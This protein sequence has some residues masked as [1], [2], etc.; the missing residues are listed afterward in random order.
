[1]DILINLA[2]TAAGI[3]ML[4]YGGNWLV[5]GGVSVA[6]RIGMSS[7]VVGMTVVA[8]G[9]STP[10][11]A[12]SV[13]AAGKYGDIILGNIVG[14]NIA[15]VG[16]VIGIATILTTLVV[17]RR[18]LRLEVPIMVGFSALLVGLSA[19]GQISQIDG[20]ILLS[21]LGVFSVYTFWQS[22][23]HKSDEA[24]P[25]DTTSYGRSFLLMGIGVALL[26][27][28][29]ILTVDNAVAVA[30][31]VGIPQRI[32]GITVI[33]VGTSLPELITSI[34]AIRR[35]HTDIGVGNIIGSN[36][37]NILLIG[38]VSASIASIHVVPATF[39]DYTIMILFSLVL[40]AAFRSGKLRWPVGLA[41]VAGY[42]T[43]ILSALL[44]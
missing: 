21:M 31:T 6:R 16:M 17:G 33:A 5:S 44:V 26:Y 9:T 12:A 37:Y 8:Y 34:I 27:A 43:Y 22:K 39:T 28:G 35:G 24:L 29:A 36:I 20:V 25:A 30:E 40:F 13:A 14:S 3:I 11:L 19:D 2:L 32:I 18:T 15:N 4:C 10:E 23:S 1:M 42:V 38:G 7:M 41:L